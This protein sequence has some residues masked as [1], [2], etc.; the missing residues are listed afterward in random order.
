MPNPSCSS[1]A[2]RKTAVIL[3]LSV[4]IIEDSFVDGYR[5]VL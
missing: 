1:I 5:G 2:V 4:H 3:V